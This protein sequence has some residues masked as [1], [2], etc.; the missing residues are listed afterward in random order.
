MDI[1]LKLKQRKKLL[2][3]I[4]IILV[5]GGYYVYKSNSGTST[6]PSYITSPVTRGTLTVSTSGTGQVSALNQVDIKPKISGNLEA[7]Y[8]KKDQEVKTGQLLAKVNTSDAQRAVQDAEVNLETAQIALAELLAPADELTIMQAEN[9]VV[10]AQDTKR[11]AE[12]AIAQGYEDAF[13]SV[14]DVFFDLPT[15]ITGTQDALYSYVIARS[16]VTIDDG[17]WNISVLK[18]SIKSEDLAGLEK[19]INSA[20]NNYKIAREKYDQNFEDYRNSSRYSENSATEALLGETIDTL[21]AISEAVK[22]EVN[23]FDYWVDS[24][25]TYGYSTYSKVTQY[26]S[27]LKTY[28]SKTNTYLTN[29]LNVKEAFQNNRQALT[30][31]EYSI[32]EKELTLK[33]LK[34]GP[35]ELDIKTKKIAIQQKQAALITA[36]NNLADCYIY[37]PFAGVIALVSDDVH[38]GDSISTSTVLASLITTQ[39]IAEISLNEVDVAKVKIGQKTTLT[40]DAIEDLSLT[41]SVAD[42]ATTGTVSQGVVSYDVKILFDTED[43]RI[44]PGMS[45]SASIITDA[46]QDVLLVLNSAVKT[47]GQKSYVQVLQDNQ[48]Q[49]RTVQVGLSNDTSSEISGDI[50]EGEQVVTKIVNGSTTK[51]TTTKTESTGS[52]I[53]GLDGGRPIR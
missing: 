45:V 17:S 29:L 14:T 5:G 34:D 35:D 51:S 42:V 2:I 21:R 26:Q 25:T 50:K 24:R 6:P 39:H 3:I 19:F 7:F 40:F 23:L 44:K 49:N 43:E 46:K 9:A 28:T 13:N 31:A 48:P 1:I 10:K 8:I 11:T 18:N 15:I 4:A 20:E 33:E 52:I 47:Q 30:D 12:A 53:P 16:E 38:K 41:G 22:S 37:A 27:D 32:K 36:R